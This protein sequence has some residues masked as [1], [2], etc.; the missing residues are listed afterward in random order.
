M[1]S[2]KQRINRRTFVGKSAKA[3]A[4][5][6]LAPTFALAINNT[7]KKKIKLVLVGTGVRGI[8]T[9][10]K[11]LVK[12]YAEQVEMTGLC[13]INKKRV[14]VAREII[15]IK[16]K[17]YHSSQFDLMIEEQ[18]PDLV[19]IATTDNT[20]VDYIIRAMELG[21]NVI[22]EK[23]I[24]TDELQCQRILDAEKTYGKKVYVGFNV[25]YMNE[26]IE[27]KRL[28]NEGEIGKVISIE[29]QEYLDTA[30]GASYFR[31]WHGKT[32]YSGSLFVHKSS[33]HFDLI[34][35]ILDADP[36]EVRAM[37][38]LAFYGSNKKYRGKNCR[39]CEFTDSCDFYWDITKNNE[40]TK[41][42][43]NCETEDNY[44][45]DGCVW[46]TKI[47]SPDSGSVLVHYDNG[48][49]LNY[50]LNAYLPYEGQKIS[51]SGEK[52][53]LDVRLY[54][55]QPWLEQTKIEF[56]LTRD[57]RT[58]KTWEITPDKGNHGGADSKIKDSFFK[59]NQESTYKQR[60]GS[61]AGVLS[62][63]IGIAALKSI[64][65]GK[66]IKIKEIIK[67]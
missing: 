50:S 33:H 56:R 36:V 52:G 66:T 40:L 39:N 8:H 48:T 2:N 1:A 9:W 11:S 15:G 22:S 67:L 44:Y 47:D 12:S 18:K 24:A 63:L 34:N 3:A 43:V 32:N 27:M 25:R 6:S 5:L 51:F 65:S 14:E 7:N 58:T 53:R 29:Y 62:S 16:V 61:R 30:H 31:R 4:L 28:I 19:I 38:K 55:N 49:Q 17:T 42:Y 26:S 60:A 37:G 57:R 35:W 46:D 54:Y 64:K 59:A 45:R 41:L 10:G 23:P 20:H 13:D 21:C